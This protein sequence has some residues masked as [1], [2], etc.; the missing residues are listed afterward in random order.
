MT[1][2]E[3]LERR[4]REALSPLA[5]RAAD[6]RGRERPEQEHDL[7]TAFQRD[8][9][10]ILHTKA[11]RRLKRK[12]QVFLAPEDD[13]YRTRLTHTLEVAQIARTVA[14]ALFMNEDLTEAIALGHDLGHTPF[15][16]AGE[17]VL[18]EVHPLGFHHSEQSLRI[19]DKLESTRH[20]RGLNLTSEVRDGI[21]NHSVGKRILTG[22]RER[23][24]ATVEGDIVSVCDAIAYVNHDIDDAVRGGIITV[25]DLPRNA[26]LQ[27]GRSSS[28]RIN[29]M[30]RALVEGSRGGV[31]GMTDDVR[32]ATVAL[33]TYLYENLYPCD[34]IHGEIEKAKRLVRGLY[35]YLLEH[36]TKESAAGDPDDSLEQRTVDFI[37]GMTDHFALQLHRRIFFPTAWP[38]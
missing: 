32:E 35:E 19:V 14:R 9:D 33:R 26:T 29:R 17:A 3:Q 38:L 7:R 36:P 28:E 11:F 37:A 34:A 12:T 25:D 31:V 30:V 1:V 20:G 18:N 24:A 13:H 5:A 10:R 4:E 8:R 2:R 22:A 6:S 27:L 16:H 21:F 15:G 23:I